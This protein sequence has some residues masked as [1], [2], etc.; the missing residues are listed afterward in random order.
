MLFQIINYEKK[1]RG[2]VTFWL[3]MRDVVL[4]V[5]RQSQHLR[6]EHYATFREPPLPS[7]FL[8]LGLGLAWAEL[9][10]K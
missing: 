1:V 5:R 10:E 8:N 7:S 2:K 4:K 3:C 6:L 9:E